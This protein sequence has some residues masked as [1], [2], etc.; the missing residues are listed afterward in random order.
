MSVAKWSSPGSEVEIA[1]NA[2]N[3]LASSSNSARMAYDNSTNRSLYARVTVEL[4]SITPANGGSITL[5]YLGRR[6]GS[7]ETI[8]TG[9]ESYT[10][11]T[12]STA[13]TKRLIFELV[14]LY[15][16]DG[17]FIITNGTGVTLAASGNAVYVQ[18]FGEEVV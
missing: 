15:P 5:R 16:F 3:S 1:G 8:T 6:S 10:L 12:G 14:R 4:G 9:L 13:G 7:D 11:P 17:G 2:L 18:P